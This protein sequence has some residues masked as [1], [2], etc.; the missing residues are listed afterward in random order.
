MKNKQQMGGVNGVGWLGVLMGL[1]I[2]SLSAEV[3]PLTENWHLYD[4]EGNSSLS[5]QSATGFEATISDLEDPTIAGN[6]PAVVQE[7]E[8]VDVSEV[9]ASLRVQFDVELLTEVIDQ[10]DTD[11]RFSFYDTSTNFE[12]IVGMVDLGSPSGTGMRLRVDNY[13]STRTVDEVTEEEIPSDFEPGDYSHLG[14]GGGTL[15]PSGGNP[16]GD[17]LK[18]LQD[19]HSFEATVTRISPSELE[20]VTQWVVEPTGGFEQRW[21]SVA[22]VLNEAEPVNTNDVP[23]GGGF[24]TI[25]GFG[26]RLNDANPFNADGNDETVES[27]SYRISSLQIDR[28]VLVSNPDD[29]FLYKGEG[30]EITNLTGV[31]ADGFT[32][33][34]GAVAEG[35]ALPA[36]TQQFAP[37]A[38]SEV[39][40]S[41]EASFDLKLLSD[42]YKGSDTDFRFGFFD[43]A[44]NFEFVLGMIDFGPPGGTAM[45]I[46]VDDH[47]SS[48]EE[49]EELTPFIE[50][51]FAVFLSAGGT[52]G[53]SGDPNLVGLQFPN[54]TS[55]FVTRVTRI[56]E[57]EVEMATTWYNDPVTGQF[58]AITATALIDES[59]PPNPDDVPPSG[60]F[61]QLN[62][63]GFRIFD[64]HPFE[65]SEN[66][67]V[68]SG[69]FEISN[70]RLRYCGAP[71]EVVTEG[72]EVI[73]ITLQ[74]ESGDYL[75]EWVA[76]DGASY[77][78]YK[79]LDLVDFGENPVATV[80]A[81]GPTGSYLIP[82]TEVATDGRAFFRL[83]KQ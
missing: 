76:E 81:S 52:L 41:I 8:P 51:D 6:R 44:S 11:F 62:G 25:N 23:P 18:F 54:D 1:G 40:Q 39:G 83:S 59:A 17:G 60:T 9:G 12:I 55:R 26:F 69:S 48:Y 32:A 22:A 21:A 58:T 64:A 37:L 7:F 19:V 47:I 65:D 29:W 30:D 50:G 36:I 49:G 74:P 45:R 24:Q 46:R 56:S 5:A 35:V 79:S 75:V 31:S 61:T 4:P 14:E 10:N 67:S 53:Q 38:L 16:G 27:G 2:L 43:T 42:V 72:I 34:I 77:D 71:V 15:S 80:V 73:G 28:S 33:E 57:T 68:D 20:I 78:V 63:F 82:A 66:P 70:F 13:I 3:V